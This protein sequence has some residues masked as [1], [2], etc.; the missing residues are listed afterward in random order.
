[1]AGL[2]RPFA[3]DHHQCAIATSHG[4]ALDQTGGIEAADMVARD[5]LA[6]AHHELQPVASGASQPP[7]V[8]VLRRSLES[9]R[10]EVAPPCPTVG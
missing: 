1:V 7:I 3:R 10:L 9:A 5:A 8:V 6:A 4:H 2:Q